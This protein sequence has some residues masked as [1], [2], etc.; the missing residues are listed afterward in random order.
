MTKLVGLVLVYNQIDYIDELFQ[1]I[2]HLD[3]LNIIISDD[4]SSD[5][6]YERLCE[7]TKDTTNII[8]SQNKRNLGLAHH[9]YDKIS[10]MDADYVLPCAGDDIY[11]PY[12]VDLV[13]KILDEFPGRSFYDF[14][15]TEFSDFKDINIRLSN[16]DI[17]VTCVTREVGLND[18]FKKNIGFSGC[19]RVYSVR[20]MKKFGAFNLNT[21]TED[22]T[23]LLRC[24]LD[25]NG[26]K[27]YT[28]LI[29]Y[30]IHENSLTVSGSFNIS[31]RLD[32]LIQHF[33]D[34]RSTNLTSAVKQGVMVRLC[35]VFAR[36][37]LADARIKVIKRVRNVF[38]S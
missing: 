6:S 13:R 10:S 37:V 38:N 22:K 9:F 29:F 3:G 17:P 21:P 12:S 31:K 33:A 34:L 30:R 23:S 20:S 32:I 7:L 14:D 24:L 16:K 5:G 11:Y 1:G 19:S 27:I 2:S 8:L 15:N 28:P 4:C 35:L 18:F 36:N 26:L 25:T